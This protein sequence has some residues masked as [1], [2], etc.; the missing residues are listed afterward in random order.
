MGFNRYTFHY[1]LPFAFSVFLYP[2]CHCPILR[3]FY[4]P[5]LLPLRTYW[6]YHVLQFEPDNLAPVYTPEESERRTMGQR[7]SWLHLL[8]FCQQRFC[9][10]WHPIA[11]AAL[12]WRCL[13][14]F[15]FVVLI[16]IP[17]P[18]PPAIGSFDLTSRLGAYPFSGEASYC[19]LR[20]S[21][22]LKMHVTVGNAWSYK[23]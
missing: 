11:F 7:T 20:T 18:P 23:R 14:R 12:Q 22:L 4:S 6:A 15:T 10:F 16:I 2:L 19:E 17:F 9:L 8:T 13:R 3:R 21:Q 5:K 1:K